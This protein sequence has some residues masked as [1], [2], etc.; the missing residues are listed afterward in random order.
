M[1][2][3]LDFKSVILCINDKDI[4]KKINVKWAVCFAE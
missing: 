3:N 1:S 2:I 4:F